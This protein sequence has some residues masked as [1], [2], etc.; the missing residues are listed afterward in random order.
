MKMTTL[1][2]VIFCILFFPGYLLVFMGSFTRQKGEVRKARK[3]YK[4]IHFYGPFTAMIIYIS[5]ILYALI[6]IS[7]IVSGTTSPQPDVE[8]DSKPEAT[9][10]TEI[11]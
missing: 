5:I 3:A 9:Q 4:E 1:Q 7:A 2:K 8:I 10:T 11:S 6:V